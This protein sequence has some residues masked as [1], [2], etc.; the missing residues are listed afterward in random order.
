MVRV[1]F[2]VGCSD[3]SSV[4]LDGWGGG[5]DGCAFRFF[6]SITSFSTSIQTSMA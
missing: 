1:N 5:G 3:F 2:G 4:L 6:H